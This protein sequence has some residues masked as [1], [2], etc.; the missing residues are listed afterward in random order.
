MVTLDLGHF[1]ENTFVNKNCQLIK[2]INLCCAHLHFLSITFTHPQPS[3]VMMAQIFY[4]VIYKKINGW[5]RLLERPVG[6][7]SMLCHSLID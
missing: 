4:A 7:G 6:W 3:L 5:D 1:V 2:L